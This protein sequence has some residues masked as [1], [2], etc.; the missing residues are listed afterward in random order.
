MSIPHDYVPTDEADF[1]RCCKDPV[2]RVAS[3]M[4]YKIIAK[5]HEGDEGHVIPFRPN[6]AQRRLLASLWHRNVILK[7]RQLGFSTLVCILWLDHALFVAD[8]RCGIVAQDREAAES[9]FRDK[10]QF[11]YRNLPEF[12]REAM[13]LARD[14]ASELLFAHNNSSVRVA[15]S[16]RSG[17]INRLHVSEFGKICARYP[18]KAREVTSGSLPAVPTDGIAIIESTAEGREGAFF[19]MCQQAQQLQQRGVK[20]SPKDWRF[21]FFPWWSEP[22]YSLDVDRGE[23]L[24]SDKDATYFAEVEQ[25]IG[26]EL[27]IEQRRWYVATRE[28]DFAGDPELM[29]QEHPSTP[30]EPFRVSAEGTYYAAQLADARKQG[31]IGIVP[32]NPRLAVNTFWD[33]GGGDGTG[34]WLHQFDGLKH[35]FPAYIEGWGEPYSFY[36]AKLQQFRCVWGKHHLPHDAERKIQQGTRMVA[37]IDELKALNIGGKWV[38]VPR[39]AEL[40]VGIQQTREAFSGAVFDAE[41]CKEGLL[42]LAGYRKSWNEKAGAW[43]DTPVKNVHTEGADSFRQWAQS[44]QSIE[45]VVYQQRNPAP[46]I[47]HIDY[48]VDSETGM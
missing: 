36:V 11:A 25:Q 27:T 4:L 12:L 34:I 22:T 28:S 44:K 29:W 5:T 42:H 16:M 23:V 6:R 48:G 8:Q 13:P 10:V 14:S 40:S 38:I 24:F 33:I 7:A 26:R 39:V 37:A 46:R 1:I 43:S 45:L 17:T 19:A 35:T 30:D 21:H 3:G 31:R 47:Q 9:L 20:L 15:T 2:W 41:G 32:I 18:D